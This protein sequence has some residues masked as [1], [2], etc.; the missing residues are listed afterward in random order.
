MNLVLFVVSVL[1]I[2]VTQEVVQGKGEIICSCFM[3][4]YWS[5]AL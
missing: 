3:F 1:G 4:D 5:V 2:V